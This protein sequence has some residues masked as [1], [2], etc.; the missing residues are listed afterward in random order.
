M[1][2][3]V[4]AV[5]FG[6]DDFKVAEGGR[7]GFTELGFE[8]F[9]VDDDGV[10][11]VFDLVTDAGGEAA[12]GGHAAGEL[13]L[14]L[15]GLDGL[16]IVEGEERA[17]ALSRFAVVDELKG[18]FDAA[19]GFSDDDFLGQRRGG[20]ECLAE[21]AAESS[22][23]VEDLVCLEA[24]YGSLFA[25]EKALGGLRNENGAVVGGEQEDAVLKVA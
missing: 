10:D 18:E 1:D 23:G 9:E 13:E 19:A 8:Q 3:A 7:A 2:D 20:C 5:D 6:V 17:Q 14:G 22:I 25:G 16:K 15:D 24:E 4:E 21:G 12:D 11:G